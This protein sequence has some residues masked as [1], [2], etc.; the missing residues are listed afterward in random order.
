MIVRLETEA[1]WGRI[2]AVHEAAFPGPGEA[3]LVDQLR[4]DGDLRVSLVAVDGD[5]SVVGHAAFSVMQAPFRAL[6]LG[7]VGVRPDRQGAGVGGQLIR[8]GLDRAEA[9]G[10]QAVFV[11][12]DPPYYGR[13]GFQ[14]RL[15]AG[16]QSPYAGPHFMARWL[17]AEAPPVLTGSVA[18]PAAFRALD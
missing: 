13:F 17:G 15:A 12:G 11:L 10:W 2:R 6:G 1:D 4:H 18:Y 8:E 5:G 14:A 3:N 16:F 7:P 9:G